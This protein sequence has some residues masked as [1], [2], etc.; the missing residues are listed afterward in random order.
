MRIAILQHADHEGP[1]EIGAWARERGHEVR[2]THLY[3]DEPPP[4]LDSFDLLVVMGGEMNVYQYRDYPWLLPERRLIASALAAGRRVVG[5]CLG[6]QLIADAL[7]ARVTQNPEY[8]LG[9][10]PVDSTPEGRRL[11]PSLPE[12]PTVLHWH[13]DT[14]ELP[15]GA[16]PLAASPACPNQGFAVPG[17]CLALQFHFEADA[18]LAATMVQGQE[19]NWPA[20]RFVQSGEEIRRAAAAHHAENRRILHGMLDTFCA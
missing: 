11:F 16:T 3:R 7:G 20:G 14:F 1:G 19:P 15:A 9:W 6:A 8:E 13:G 12:K 17:Q 10:F 18:E 5:I 2:V 4:A